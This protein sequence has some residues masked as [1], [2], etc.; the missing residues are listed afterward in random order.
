MPPTFLPLRA[1]RASAV[2]LSPPMADGQW[3]MATLLL[4]YSLFPIPYS[5]FPDPWSLVPYPSPGELSA[6]STV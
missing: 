3:P 2:N 4:P 6:P 5:L 1:F